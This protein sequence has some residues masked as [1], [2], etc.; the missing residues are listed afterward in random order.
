MNKEIERL[1]TLPWTVE[2]RRNHDGSIFARIIEL[3]GCMTEG[4]NRQKALR[5][6]DEALR[7]WLAVEMEQGAFIPIPLGAKA[8]SG[9]FMVRTSPVVHR[10]AAEAAE[11]H[12]VSLNEFASEAIALLASGAIPKP[13]RRSRRST[14]VD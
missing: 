2:M 10:L 8:Y 13:T 7:L 12:G 1:A 6:L 3:P 9:K 4:A 14:P 11:H 5:N